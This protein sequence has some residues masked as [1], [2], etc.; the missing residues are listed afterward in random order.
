MKTFDSL[1]KT[2]SF[3]FIRATKP[4]KSETKRGCQLRCSAD[5]KLLSGHHSGLNPPFLGRY[6]QAAQDK[7]INALIPT[8]RM[9]TF[10]IHLHENNTE[11]LGTMFFFPAAAHHRG[12]T[13]R[14]SVTAHRCG[15][16]LFSLIYLLV[17]STFYLTDFTNKKQGAFVV[18]LLMRKP[19]SDRVRPQDLFMWHQ[20]LLK[21]EKTLM[22]G[23]R[24]RLV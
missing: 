4:H 22:S 6:N 18:W 2:R 9:N 16:A 10:D 8:P 13:R 14:S 17:R 7:T 20:F 5:R 21:S 15:P 1:E 23:D 11:E 24:G 3:R 19:Q 12:A